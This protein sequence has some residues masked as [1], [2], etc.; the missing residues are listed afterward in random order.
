MILL[1]IFKGK[2]FVYNIGN[3]YE[4]VNAETIANKIGK[5]TNQNLNLVKKVPYQKIILMMNQKT[6]SIN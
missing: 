3:P 1:S 6:L 2:E 4:E 5:V